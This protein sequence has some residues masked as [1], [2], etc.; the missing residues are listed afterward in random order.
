V[1]EHTTERIREIT[2]PEQRPGKPSIPDRPHAPA[3][4]VVSPSIAPR[5]APAAPSRRTALAEGTGPAPSAAV[6]PVVHVTIG[7]V[8][9]RAVQAS[10]A[11]PATTRPR[12]PR[13]GLD[14]YLARRER[15]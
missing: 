3:R 14:D 4:A 7:R 5:L 13:M 15:R 9:V 1:R 2:P 6:E 8:E 11:K 10:A 12:E